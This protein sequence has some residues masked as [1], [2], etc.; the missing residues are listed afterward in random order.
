[1]LSKPLHVRTNGI[2]VLAIVS[3]VDFWLKL[4]ARQIPACAVLGEDFD[5]S[6]HVHCAV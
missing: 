3:S 6:N 1:M 4:V 2:F 5:Y